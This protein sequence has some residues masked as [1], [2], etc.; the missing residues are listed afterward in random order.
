MLNFGLSAAEKKAYHALLQSSHT[1]AIWVTIMDLDHNER[2][3]VSKWLMDGQITVDTDAAV[4]RS[5]S[6]DLLDPYGALHLDSKSPSDGAMFADRMLRVIYSIVNPTRTKRYS[7]PIF[8]GPITKLDRNGVMIT[9][10]AQGK[11]SLGLATPWQT[12]TYKKGYRVTAAIQDILEDIIGENKLDIP[13][14]TNKLPR[15]VSVGTTFDKEGNRTV[16]KSPWEVA[17]KLASSIGYQLFYNGW[18][19][20]TM[21]KKQTSPC[22]TFEGES[23][24]A[25]KSVPTVGFNLDRVVNAVEVFG[26][27]PEKEEGKTTKKQ[28]HARIVAPRSHPLSPWSLG[29]SGGPRYLP[30]VIEDDVFWTDAEAMERA[31]DELAYGLLSSYALA[32]D[33]LVIPHLEE[34]DVVRLNSEKFSN[35]HLMKQF[36]IPLT[37][38]G[39]MTVGY[40]RNVKVNRARLKQMQR[41]R[42][43]A[44]R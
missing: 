42:R 14:L 11:E 9:V 31:K 6:L 40:A 21:R 29:R 44:A 27:K 43:R 16:S 18:G 3:S 17:K 39:T 26:K 12:K 36:A 8:T 35:N 15:N 30:M 4:T 33:A 41:A 32:Y 23:G 34:L 38:A 28:P 5:L 25:L 20:A 2:T 13:S 24:G 7:C 10:E 1:I 19:I 37:S 22:F